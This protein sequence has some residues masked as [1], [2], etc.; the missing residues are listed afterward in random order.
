MIRGGAQIDAGALTFGEFF[1][2]WTFLNRFFTPVRDLAEKYNLLQSAM[3]SAERVFTIL[4]EDTR[5]PVPAEATKSDQLTEGIHFENVSFQYDEDTP[6]LT[7]VSF[8]VAPGETVALVGATGAGKSTVV[9]L[10]LRYY[11]PIA[12]KITID[13]TDLRTFQPSE[14]RERFG[15]VLQDVAVMSRTLGENIDF[16]RGL[17]RDKILWAA[18]QVNATRLIERQEA[19]L[20]EVMKER[21]RTLSSGERQL[22]S[23]ARALAGDPEILVLDEATASLDSETEALIQDALNKLTEGRTSIIIA[24]RLST[25][26]T[27]DKILVFHRGE[28]REEGNHDA[29]MAENGIYAR[30][31]RLQYG[32]EAPQNGSSSNDSRTEK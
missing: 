1:L 25:I 15:L 19:G 26:R 22:V 3:A 2:F 4:D 8:S 20:D 21:G 11:D 32:A 23:F 27:A 14:H 5:L 12:G 17:G 10:L 30:L 24:H 28:L 18:E 6:V 7:D 16:D 29:L 31:Y 13:G 9:N